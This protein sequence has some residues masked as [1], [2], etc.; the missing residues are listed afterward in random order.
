MCKYNKCRPGNELASLD[1][2]LSGIYNYTVRFADARALR[3]IIT[4]IQCVATGVTMRSNR[5]YAR[6]PRDS[7]NQLA[8]KVVTHPAT[9]LER[10]P[11]KRHIYSTES[12][13]ST[14]TH[15]QSCTKPCSF[16]D[17][18]PPLV[19]PFVNLCLFPH[20]SETF[21]IVWS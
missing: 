14:F 19:S 20:A 8:K 12:P 1:H 17:F 16:V 7:F 18:R 3:P 6:R 11:G 2:S 10:T 21:G 4:F 13:T 15:G 5:A 9:L